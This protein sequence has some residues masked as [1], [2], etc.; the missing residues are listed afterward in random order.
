MAVHGEG[1]IHRDL[2]PENVML[3]PQG[4]IKVLDF[5]L[6]RSADEDPAFAGPTRITGKDAGQAGTDSNDTATFAGRT[7]RVYATTPELRQRSGT[8][9]SGSS[10]STFVKTSHGM[11]LG[12]VGYMSP[13]QARGEPAS[14]ASDM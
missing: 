7:M 14:A 6:A 12:T 8:P 5:G 4:G 2:K 10:R 9:G 11:V 13:E 1:V 3:T